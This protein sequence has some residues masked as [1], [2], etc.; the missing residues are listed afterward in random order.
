MSGSTRKIAAWQKSI[1][2]EHLQDLQP[3]LNHNLASST[4]QH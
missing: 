3:S 2:S 4:A 1:L